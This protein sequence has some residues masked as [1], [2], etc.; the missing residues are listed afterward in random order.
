MNQTQTIE[1]AIKQELLAWDMEMN[2]RMDALTRG[3][4]TTYEAPPCGRSLYLM[5]RAYFEHHADGKPY[6]SG[7]RVAGSLIPVTKTETEDDGA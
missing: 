7:A 2:L 4:A 6:D 5:L 3:E 1:D